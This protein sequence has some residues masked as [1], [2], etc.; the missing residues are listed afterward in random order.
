[1]HYLTHVPART[2]LKGELQKLKIKRGARLDSELAQ[3]QDERAARIPRYARVNTNL[4]SL[5]DAQT[6]LRSRGFVE[7]DPFSSK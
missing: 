5:E 3:G 6:E 1:M 7:A 2:R 4:C